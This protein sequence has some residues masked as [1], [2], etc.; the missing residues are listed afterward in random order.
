MGSERQT[1]SAR[2]RFGKWAGFYLGTF[3]AV[4]HQQIVTMTVYA[5]CPVN[6]DA[7]VLGIGAICAIIGS[8]GAIYSWRTRQALPHEDTSSTTLRADR[9]LAT[10]AAAFAAFCVLFIIFAATAGVI[11]RCER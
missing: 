4:A 5:R 8:F 3:A 9:F 10:L 1:F 6:S 2:L 11:L 7:L